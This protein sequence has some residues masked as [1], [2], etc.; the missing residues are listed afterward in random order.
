MT[1]IPAA[2][3]QLL[4]IGD[5]VRTDFALVKHYEGQERRITRPV[6]GSVL[7]SV[8]GVERS[9]GWILDRGVVSF[10]VPPA[11]GEEIR[12]GFRFDV[13]VRF[14]EDRLSLNRATF[15]AGEAPSVP[16]VEVRE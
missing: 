6:P 9:S 12:A 4:G 5:G 15:A 2:A 11:V 7:V 10:G 3:D 16:L 13:P 1:G 8:G 14:A